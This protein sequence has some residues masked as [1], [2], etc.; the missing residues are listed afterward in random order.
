MEP[1]W[2]DQ[3]CIDQSSD[4]EKAAAIGMMD[5]LYSN[6]RV[7]TVCLEDVHLSI[8]DM[9]TLVEFGTYLG[10]KT[11]PILE[12]VSGIEE[13]EWRG[14]E[15][16]LFEAVTKIFTARWFS[17]AWCAHE[18][19]TGRNLVFLA[20][21]TADLTAGVSEDGDT[22]I[23]RFNS[24]FLAYAHL[25]TARWIPGDKASSVEKKMRHWEEHVKHSHPYFH[26]GIFDF[27]AGQ[28]GTRA[29]VTHSLKYFGGFS[30]K[31]IVPSH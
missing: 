31:R 2:I 30:A 12:N 26:A 28:L 18:F 11:M 4:N 15:G 16:H 24:A 9:A 29:S 5:L 19:W 13:L 22:T 1:L 10:R 3:S 25:L 23:I 17:R 27:G 7:V 6:A 8:K 20:P 14:K 21:V